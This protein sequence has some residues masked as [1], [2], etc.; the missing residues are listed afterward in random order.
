MLTGAELVLAHQFPSFVGPCSSLSSWSWPWRRR[1]DKGRALRESGSHRSDKKSFLG[2]N[3]ANWPLP[4]RWLE[5]HD[6]AKGGSDPAGYHEKRSLQTYKAWQSALWVSCSRSGAPLEPRT[7]EMP[8]RHAAL[9]RTCLA[10][11]TSGTDP[12]MRPLSLPIFS[13]WS[14][15]PTCLY[16]FL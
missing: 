1:N 15:C 16:T 6:K 7:Q 8:M 5:L 12:V 10:N 3:H 4:L 9:L 2:R 13:F 11:G 14:S